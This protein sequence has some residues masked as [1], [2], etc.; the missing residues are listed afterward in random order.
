MGCQGGLRDIDYILT[1]SVPI[2]LFKKNNYCWHHIPSTPNDVESA[3]FTLDSDVVPAV[4]CSARILHQSLV[5]MRSICLSPY[6]LN[7]E[8]VGT[9]SVCPINRPVNE[10]DLK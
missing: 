7:P 3:V 5:S 10:A 4:I 9:S 1:H 2:G 6:F 8:L